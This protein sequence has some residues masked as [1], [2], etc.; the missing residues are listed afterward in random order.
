MRQGAMPPSPECSRMAVC[1]RAPKPRCSLPA[2]ER[3]R[4]A[5][6]PEP[7]GF[8]PAFRSFAQAPRARFCARRNGGAR[9]PAA[10][11]RQI[12]P[13]AAH[14]APYSAR[15]PARSAASKTREAGARTVNAS[16]RRLKSSFP[17][18]AVRR[19]GIERQ[20]RGHNRHGVFAPAHQARD[21]VGFR[22]AVHA[23]FQAVLVAMLARTKIV[24][25][26]DPNPA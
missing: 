12:R 15:R 13:A 4:G 3:D 6:R 26:A 21:L 7:A 23:A 2:R 16:G 1:R 22:Q 20:A 18:I 10:A 19:G 24:A 11:A 17:G 14:A 9:N 5:W 25:G 8:A